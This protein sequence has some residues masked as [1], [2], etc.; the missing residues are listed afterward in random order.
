VLTLIVVLTGV[1]V[2]RMGRSIGSRE[3]REAAAR[4]A[5]TARTVRE[6]AV[7][8]Q[9]VCAIEIDLDRGGYGVAT[10]SGGDRPGQWQTLQASWLKPQRW[11]AT[12]SIAS[13]RTPD[14]SAP[15]SGRQYL[16][17]F[18]DGT[19]SGAALRLA[20]RED[21]YDIVVHPHSGRVVYGDHEAAAFGLDTYDL[22]D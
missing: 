3:L 2:P 16:K 17:F 8:R 11:P 20:G 10:Q 5:L 12:I 4:F 21:E 22:G 18:P 19:S 9:R 1:I 13:Y 15:A 7:A 6:L 14:G